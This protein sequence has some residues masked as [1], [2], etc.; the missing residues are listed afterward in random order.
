M[1]P[2]AALVIGATFASFRR[3]SPATASAVQHLAAGVVFAAAATEVLPDVQHG[4]SALAIVL[5][6][7][8][9]LGLMFAIK[10]VGSRL[11]GKWSLVALTG[12]DILIDGVV[13]G[14]GFA[15]GA[16]QGALL[17]FALTLEILFLGLAATE[18]LL[19]NLGSK[20]KVIAAVALG[21]ALLP[22]GAVLGGPV[23]DLPPFWLTAALS[24]ALIALL[25]LVTEELLVEA[26]QKPDSP[27]VTSLFFVGFLGLLVIEGFVA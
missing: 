26:H 19:E 8:A 12:I 18:E 24:F 11:P 10:A 22:L 17:L 27:L 7:S 6:G 25:Y 16:K 21:G 5:G 2:W 1:L 15:A 9:G 20:G 4:G 13:L 14:I 23:H 3:P